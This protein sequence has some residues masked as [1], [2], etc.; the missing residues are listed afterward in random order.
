MPFSTGK[1]FYAITKGASKVDMKSLHFSIIIPVKEINH[2]LLEENFPA[3]SK[4]SYTNFEV[5]VL[6]NKKSALDKLLQKKYPWLKI[7][8]TG[9]VTR[10]AQKRDIGVKKSRGTIIAFI[11]DDAYPTSNWL[12][13]A[14]AH[15][16]KSE[17]AAVCGPGI[18]PPKANLWE[19]IFDEVLKTW[20][21]SGGYGYRFIPQR[22][23][24][25]DDYPSMNFLVRRD[26]FLELGGFNSD[27]WPGEDSK[28]CEDIV[29]K[30]KKKILYHPDVVIYHHRRTDL[31]AFLKQ[32][33]RYGFHRGAFFAHGDRNS[34]RVVYLAPTFFISYLFSLPFIYK[35]SII[36]F[37]LSIIPL[38]IYL[39]CLFFVLISSLKNTRRLKIAFLSTIVLF[40]MHVVYGVRFIYGFFT[41]LIR[42]ENIYD[43]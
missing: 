34:R 29:Y 7:V 6:P 3:L 22:S 15:F 24:F 36:D 26:I 31:K 13:K 32:H 30:K 1:I 16:E 25:I 27:Y 9:K 43:H 20:V 17:I 33:G 4:L 5:I 39:L 21:G 2:Y 10:P 18:L 40:L 35:F 8:P 12:K 11:D 14:E 23:R 42:R 28:L 19:R 41:G 38:I 37:Q